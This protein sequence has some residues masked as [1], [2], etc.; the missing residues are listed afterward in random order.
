MRH[1]L[2][3]IHFGLDITLVFLDVFIS[4]GSIGYSEFPHTH[5][6]SQ[7]SAVAVEI[8]YTTTNLQ[9]ESAVLV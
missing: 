5:T 4:V 2:H 3:C 8:N 9:E 1:S 6:N 7:I